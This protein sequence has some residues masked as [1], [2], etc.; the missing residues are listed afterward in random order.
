[1]SSLTRLERSLGLLEKYQISKQLVHAY[2]N[3]TMTATLEHEVM[4]EAADTFYRQCFQPAITRLIET[5]ASLSMVVR[6][7]LKN[8]IHFEQLTI[9]DVA[10]LLHIHTVPMTLEELI[11]EQT[12]LEFDLDSALPLW[13]LTL[14][15]LTSTTCTVSLAM[16]HTIGDGM[17]LTILWN[18]LLEGLNTEL[19]EKESSSLIQVK[20]MEL[21]LPYEQLNPP[22]ISLLWD[23]IPVI[24]KSLIPKILPTS[25]ARLIDPLASDGWK[26]DVAAIEGET[27]DTEL[28]TVH[29]PL[30]IWKPIAEECKKRA[31]SP[32]AIIFVSMLLAW[33]RLYS[34]K[35]TEAITPI[36][37]RNLCKPIVSPTQIGN[38]VGSYSSIWTSKQ[39]D[40]YEND[41]WKMASKYQQDLRSNKT[42]S[43]KQAL[44]LKYLPEFP[45]SYCD[46]WY[47]KRKNST[48]GRTGGIELS[49]LGKF[50]CYSQGKDWRLKELYF[51]QSAQTF[52]AAFG[53]NSIS[54]NDNLYCTLGW[55]KSS[56][57]KSK[58]SAYHDIFIG[59][60]KS[61]PL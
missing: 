55:Q 39:L 24:C 45:A 37:C 40:Q 6:D 61:I 26:G 16:H 46:F 2:G 8:S 18:Q 15:P 32:H 50:D 47:D 20:K 5:H 35:T 11:K 30:D 28:R 57:D 10:K 49:D 42:D 56:L 44:F 23:V 3:I 7:K 52:T 48:F 36:N 12:S 33:K 13:R 38:F 43:A 22:V 19:M 14:V 53:V 17:S 21:P 29:V 25:F 9:I 58:I 60:L 41:V 31:I 54:V 59:I 27:H 51:A 34:G 4:G 1:M